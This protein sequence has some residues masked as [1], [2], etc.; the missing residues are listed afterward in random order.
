[1]T[2]LIQRKPTVRTRIMAEFDRR[3]SAMSPSNGNVVK[4]LKVQRDPLNIQESR[5]EA[6]N[7]NAIS[8]YDPNEN[9]IYEAGYVLCTLQ[10]QVDYLYKIKEGQQ[11]TT[12]LEYLRGDLVRELTADQ[13]L[14]EESTGKKLTQRIH[15]I[16]SSKDVDNVQDRYAAGFIE[17]EVVYRHKKTDPHKLVS[18]A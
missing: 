12:E 1:M 11:A 8:L 17:L 10:I 14:T 6:L 18:E 15:Q 9:Y 4:W 3:V 16:T 13:M 5:T 2:H 7:G